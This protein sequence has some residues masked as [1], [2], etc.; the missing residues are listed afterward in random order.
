MYLLDAAAYN[1]FVLHK[2]KN[3]TLYKTNVCRNRRFSL[4]KLASEL[5]MPNVIARYEKLKTI[6]FSGIHR[7]YFTALDCI[8]FNRPVIPNVIYISSEQRARCNE[9]TCE[10][11][12][13]NSR[14]AHVCLY[15]KH[16]FC[17]NH[18]VIQ[19]ICF[20]VV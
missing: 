11:R 12:K 7:T 10:T 16:N 17:S 5:I 19:C 2:L 9:K 4:E 1:S 18:C 20:R 8:G 15:C 14:H 13:K 3:P 6:N